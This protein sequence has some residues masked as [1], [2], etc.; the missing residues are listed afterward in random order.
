MQRKQR[1]IAMMGF[2]SVGKWS[3]WVTCKCL[4]IT[5]EIFHHAIRITNI[6]SNT[7]HSLLGKSSLSI[8]FVQGQ[9]VDSYDPTIENSEYEWWDW[10]VG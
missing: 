10:C 5:V 7:L 8:Q 6:V 2:R 3:L 1:N 9:F 4:K